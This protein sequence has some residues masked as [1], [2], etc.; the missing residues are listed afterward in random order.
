[1]AQG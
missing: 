1:P